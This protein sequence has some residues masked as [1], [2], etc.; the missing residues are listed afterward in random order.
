MELQRP[1]GALSSAQRAH[2]RTRHA[3]RAGR[4][5]AGFLEAH[6]SAARAHSSHTH[7]H[8]HTLFLAILF[9]KSFNHR[10]IKYVFNTNLKFHLSLRH[11]LERQGLLSTAL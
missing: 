3:A 10:S 4:R 2:A 9:V 1:L 11:P 7:T 6:G 8:T 5:A